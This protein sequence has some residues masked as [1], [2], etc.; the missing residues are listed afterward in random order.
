MSKA[1]LDL[2]D[3]AGSMSAGSNSI[4]LTLGL[5][6]GPVE[7]PLPDDRHYAWLRDARAVDFPEAVR[8]L[9]QRLIAK[10][11]T[12]TGHATALAFDR[13]IESIA[14]GRHKSGLLADEQ[15][16]A[17]AQLA[18]ANVRRALD[19]FAAAD[20]GPTVRT[21]SPADPAVA[22]LQERLAALEAAAGQ[23][24]RP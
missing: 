10:S 21:P 17:A 1:Y 12:F 15:V 9:A 16:I 7:L 5:T 23:G 6:L 13:A 18:R 20:R 14:A 19:A 11:G 24:A 4:C 22:A 8:L 3:A 2:P